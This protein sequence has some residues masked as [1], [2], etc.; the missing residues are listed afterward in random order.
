[1][2]LFNQIEE[3]YPEIKAWEF[4]EPYKPVSKMHGIF[5][6]MVCEPGSKISDNQ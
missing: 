5:E 3:V 4:A 6:G 1:M 2:R